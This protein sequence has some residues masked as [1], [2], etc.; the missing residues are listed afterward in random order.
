MKNHLELVSYC[1]FLGNVGTVEVMQ[2]LLVKVAMNETASWE[3][4]VHDNIHTWTSGFL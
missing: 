4:M 2:T 3:P 1:H